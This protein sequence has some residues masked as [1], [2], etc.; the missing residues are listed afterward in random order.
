MELFFC[1]WSTVIS[2][3]MRIPFL[4]R[5]CECRY[6]VMYLLREGNMIFVAQI[7]VS[8]TWSRRVMIKLLWWAALLLFHKSDF[9]TPYSKSHRFS[10]CVIMAV[11][12]ICFFLRDLQYY[13]FC[14]YYYSMYISFALNTI[15]EQ[16]CFQRANCHIIHGRTFNDLHY[17]KVKLVSGYY[18]AP[19]LVRCVSTVCEWLRHTFHF[20][21]RLDSKILGFF[22]V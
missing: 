20:L 3:V 15:L 10:I 8:L 13:R 1:I 7:I 11:A 21:F 19:K 18:C 5:T 2:R 17:L 12:Q 22:V 6:N 14:R 4:I 9:V 16:C